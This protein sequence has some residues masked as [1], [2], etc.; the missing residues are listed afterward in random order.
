MLFVAR[1]AE[2]SP[3]RGFGVDSLDPKRV[4][5]G[6]GAAATQ[7]HHQ[8]L[9]TDTHQLI[10]AFIWGTKGK[11]EWELTSRRIKAAT[12]QR[13]PYLLSALIPKSHHTS[14]MHI[15]SFKRKGSKPTGFT[16]I[17][18]PNVL[19]PSPSALWPFPCWSTTNAPV[20]PS[21]YGTIPFARLWKA[22]EEG[23]Q[24][25]PHIS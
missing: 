3:S 18:F 15:N 20:P 2:S 16:C 10:R 24:C 23:S 14:A 12:N 11:L 6:R 21:S 7:P 22:W 1:A 4:S 8:Q 19:Q 25:N 13:S 5:T 9:S 17:Y